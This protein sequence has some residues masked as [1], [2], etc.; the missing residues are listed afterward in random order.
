MPNC[1]NH[2]HLSNAC[3]LRLCSSRLWGYAGTVISRTALASLA[4]TTIAIAQP[5]PNYY[6]TVDTSSPATL[7]NT[8]HAVIDDH[9][10]F[11]YTSGGT[12]TWD[13]LEDADED[14]NNS[15]RVLDLY[16]NAS[17]AKAG[18][19]NSNYNREHT[20]PNSYGFPM[21][22][23]SNYPYTDCHQ[24][25]I[26][27][28]SYNGLR[29]RRPFD[30]G[31]ASWNE[32]TTLFTNG[33]GGGSGTYPGNSN[34][35]TNSSSPG[36]WEV[37]KDRKG[38]VARAMLYLDVR[39]EGGLHGGTGAS[40]PDL[41]LTDNTTLITQSATGS[42]EAIAY[43]GKLSALL[44]W[45]AADPVDSKEIARN[46]AVYSYQGNRNP[47]IDNPS[48]VDCI[49]GNQCG[50]PSGA[51]TPEVWINELHY[52]NVGQDINEFVEV[53]GRA[54]QSLNGW[55]LIAYDGASG[56]AYDYIHLRGTF[57]N[58]Q[59]NRG[60]LSFAFP[61]LQNG[62]DGLALVA[63]NG[64][65]LQLLSYEGTFVANNGAAQGLTS[66]NIGVIET[67]STPIGFSLRLSGS[68]NAYEQFAWQPAFTNSAGAINTTQVF[69]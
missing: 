60:V 23:G 13:I 27:N 40:E 31:N 46:N 68:G 36:G 34:W 56:N 61:G 19:G 43:M 62:I 42:N 67:S 65:V 41:R 58:Q 55:L 66:R 45:H 9:Q 24:L 10:Y 21:P 50:T 57:P 7:R 20:W 29:D 51:R 39:Y 53:A 47:F 69:Q 22:G 33:L 18:G 1:A 15:G 63:S 38:D 14:S 25:F 11:P 49:Y 16:R 59:A 17:Y 3:P 5:P 28:T 52:D 2:E 48:W 64:V 6:I 32:R 44:Q 37:W 4:L 26:C 8:L 30:N 12:D 54:G 35:R